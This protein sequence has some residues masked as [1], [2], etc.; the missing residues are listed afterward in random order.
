MTSIQKKHEEDKSAATRPSFPQLDAEHDVE[1]EKEK[2]NLLSV[3]SQQAYY[4]KRRQKKM[5][6]RVNFAWKILQENQPTASAEVQNKEPAKLS[7]RTPW[8]AAARKVMQSAS[9]KKQTD[10]SL[11]V[12]ELLTQQKTIS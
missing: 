4:L 6:N 10:L 12:S 11:I 7:G 5:M 9:A 3:K 1:E 2:K 8:K